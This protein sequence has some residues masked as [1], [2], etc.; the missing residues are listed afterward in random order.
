MTVYFINKRDLMS[1]TEARTQMSQPDSLADAEDELRVALLTRQELGQEFEDEVVESFLS[2]VEDA[3]DARVEARVSESLRGAS[4][5]RRF[6][7]PSSRRI[8]VAFGYITAFLALSIPIAAVAGTQVALVSLFACI[9]FAAATLILPD[10][11]SRT[12]RGPDK[13]QRQTEE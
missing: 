8:A 10:G 13:G 5:R 11:D 2:R 4:A 3:I 1:S 12:E 9:A 7:A 6:A